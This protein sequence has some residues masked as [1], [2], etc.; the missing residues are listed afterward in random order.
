[1]RRHVLLTAAMVCV[2]TFAYAQ[3]RRPDTRTMNCEEVQSMIAQR[4]AVVMS[5][6]RHTYDRYVSDRFQCSFSS[7]VAVRAYVPALDR[8]SCPVRRCEMYDPEDRFG[9]F[10]N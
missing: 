5:T 2:A 3:G 1:M 8:R 7:E 6:G 10:M 9:D 4:G